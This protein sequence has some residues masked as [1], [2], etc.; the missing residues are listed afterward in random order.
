M[1]NARIIKTLAAE[2]EEQSVT[3]GRVLGCTAGLLLAALG[4]VLNYVTSNSVAVTLVAVCG[5]VGGEVARVFER[6]RVQ[7]E[8]EPV[9]SKHTRKP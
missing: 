3:D 6:E 8:A 7:E 4:H 2:K 1:S 9:E 5:Y